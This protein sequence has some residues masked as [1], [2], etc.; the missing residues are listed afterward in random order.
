MFSPSKVSDLKLAGFLYTIAGLVTILTVTVSEALYP[1]YS[2]HS[3]TISD[4]G[5]IGAPTQ[6]I[7]LCD[8]L[9]RAFCFLLGSYLLFRGTGKRLPLLGFML[10]GVGSTLATVSPENLNVAIHSIGAVITFLSASAIMFYSF[11][12]IRSPFRYFSA[13][14]AVVSLLATI[15]LFLGYNSSFVQDTLGP[16][17]WERVIAYPILIWLVGFGSQLLGFGRVHES[18]QPH[19][20][21]S[22]RS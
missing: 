17:G 16:G 15:I 19:M 11:K 10:P 4:L 7:E 14:L 22:M 5:A 13:G 18:A 2:I 21:G 1:N 3:N 12:I 20:P 6:L 8:G 9:L